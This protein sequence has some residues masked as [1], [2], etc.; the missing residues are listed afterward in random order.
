MSEQ[1]TAQQGQTEVSQPSNSPQTVDWKDNYDNLKAVFDRQ[2]NE[3][4]ELRKLKEQA[5]V[6]PAEQS[7][8]KVETKGFYESLGEQE[9]N[10]VKAYL[11]E[12]VN[13]T[14]P[15]QREEV[16]K[17]LIN[18]LDEVAEKIAPKIK[19]SKYSQEVADIFGEPTV[20]SITQD[21]SLNKVMEMFG[22]VESK[23]N[24]VPMGGGTSHT[25]P[26]PQPQQNKA[27]SKPMVSLFD[28]VDKD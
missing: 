15:E 21:D 16:K 7:E 1:A 11:R 5:E 3:L 17:V 18:N 9:K 24:T 19:E 23:R 20:Q 27:P 6:K 8:E 13:N 4:G 26:S 10:S 28:H 12:Q 2:A 22:L 25:N 14:P